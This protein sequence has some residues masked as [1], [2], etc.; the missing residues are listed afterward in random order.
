MRHKKLAFDV[1]VQV[2]ERLTNVGAFAPK[3]IGTMK[4]GIH[5]KVSFESLQKSG[6][7]GSPWRGTLAEVTFVDFEL[8]AKDR[9][10]IGRGNPYKKSGFGLRLIQVK[11]RE[12]VHKQQSIK[13][14]E[15]RLS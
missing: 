6:F 12:K 10:Q 15:H 7:A 2:F 4:K 8:A 3:K 14:T 5:F 13:K 9:N 11:V 1:Q